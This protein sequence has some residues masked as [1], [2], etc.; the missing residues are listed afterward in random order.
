MPDGL[1]RCRRCPDAVPAAATGRTPSRSPTQPRRSSAARVIALG[2][3]VGVDQLSKFARA[4]HPSR[5][6]DKRTIIPG[7]LDFTHVQN[8]GVAFGLL[9][10]ADFPYKSAVMIGIAALALV[11]D[12]ALR[13]PARRPR[14]AGALSGC[15]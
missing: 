6:Y 15:R 11:G 9:N 13:A 14:A 10:A 2:A 1:D 3:I 12:L 8:T 7:L 4:S 5:S